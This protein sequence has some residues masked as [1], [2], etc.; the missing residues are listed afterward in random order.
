MSRTRLVNPQRLRSR[1]AILR[2]LRRWFDRNGYL[3]VHTPTLVAAPA[4]EANLYPLRADD[5]RAFLHT[6]PEFAMKRVLAA[7][8]CRIYQIVPCFRAEEAGVHHSREFTMLE[9]YRVGANATD[10]MDDVEDL[11]AHAAAAIHQPPPTFQRIATAALLDDTADPDAWFFE[12][13]D[14]VEPTLTTPTIVYDYPAWQSALARHRAGFADRFE[15]Y[16]GG[17]ELANAFHE[18][19]NPEALRQRWMAA[20]HSR[21]QRG[22][23]PHPIDEAFLE[24]VGRMPR[25]AGIAMGIDR[26]VMAL[27]G[28]AHIHDVQVPSDA[29]VTTTGEHP[30]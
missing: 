25:C 9:W 8:L 24:A 27:T 6:S 11:I 18:E 10:L 26:L 23:P 15:V 5:G 19:L 29:S 16:L 13:V 4:M 1:A 12:W 21:E 22:H 30:R 17:L 7:G 3:E 28:A 14:R 2:A 20:N